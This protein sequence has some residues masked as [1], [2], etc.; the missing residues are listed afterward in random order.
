MAY[1]AHCVQRPGI[2]AKWAP[3][4]QSTEGAGKGLIARVMT[5]A[6][7][8]AYTHSVN[9]RELGEGGGKFNGWM[10]G[11][12]LIIADEIRVDDRRDM[13]EVLKPMITDETIEIQRDR[14]STRLNSS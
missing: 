1:L 13:I 7:G 2:K 10:E 14:K 12:L 6:V 3:L 4:I 9:A 5:H 8:R 11:K